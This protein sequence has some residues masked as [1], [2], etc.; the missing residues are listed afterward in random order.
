MLLT[1][2]E[3][4]F[5]QYGIN[6]SE[7]RW[8]GRPRTGLLFHKGDGYM[9]PASI[10]AVGFSIF[11]TWMTAR[12]HAPLIFPFVGSVFIAGSIWLLVGRLVWDAYR[13]SVTY[14]GLT[15]DSALIAQEGLFRGLQRLRLASVETLGFELAPDGSG[16]ISFGSMS[17]SGGWPTPG[18]QNWNGGPVVPS[19]EGI[20]RARQVYDLCTSAQRAAPAETP[21]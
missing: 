8:T 2:A 1:Q 17:R 13:R 4:V 18:Y 12:G 10:Y 14:Y 21:A 7:L 3:E 15:S 20:P 6:A 19:F 5:A 11:W 16:T 9:V